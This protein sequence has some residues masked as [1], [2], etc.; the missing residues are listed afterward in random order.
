MLDF[1]AEF[2]GR[3]LGAA[4]EHAADGVEQDAAGAPTDVGVDAA[5]GTGVDVLDPDA[6][7]APAVDA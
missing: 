3:R 2:L 7:L 1:I 6:A 4:L 5:L